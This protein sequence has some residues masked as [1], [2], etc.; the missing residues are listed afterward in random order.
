[1]QAPSRT[2]YIRAYCTLFERFQ[3]HQPSASQR[4]RPFTY[5]QRLLIGFFTWMLMRRITEFTTQ[6]RWLET[7]PAEAQELGFPSL[8]HRTTL[9]RRYKSIAPTVE[10]FIEFVGQWGESIDPACSSEVLVVDGSL[11]KARGPVWHQSDRAQGRIPDKL[12]NLDQEA[13]W[14]KSGYHGWVYG[15]RLHFTC[16]LAGFPKSVQVTTG[17]LAESAVLDEVEGKLLAK[18]PKAVVGDNG[19]CKATRIR[20]WAKQGVML[21]TPAS[22]WRQGRYAQAYHRFLKQEEVGC[23]LKG[24]RSAIEPVFELLRH[25]LGTKGKQKQLPVAGVACVSTFL[26]LGVLAVQVGMLLNSI[27]GHPFRKVSTIVSAFS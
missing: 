11:F 21:V 23:W 14:S 22:T 5:A 26:S 27:W 15:Y 19:F 20:R 4:G 12:R 24:R 1:L 13:S 3:E 7:H 8:P 2:D 18:R 25:V 9:M 17:S 16:N 6:R 10:A